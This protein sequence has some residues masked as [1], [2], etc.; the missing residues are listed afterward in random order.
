V[1]I[2]PVVDLA[3]EPVAQLEW[4]PA[5]PELAVAVKVFT[6]PPTMLARA[7]PTPVVVA[8]VQART[9]T[10]VPAVTVDLV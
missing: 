4:L 9:S 3:V 5:L 1:F 7:W 2:L 6:T 10:T 8:V